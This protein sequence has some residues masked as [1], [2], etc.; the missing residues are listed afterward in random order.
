MPTG[1]QLAAGSRIEPLSIDGVIN[2][3]T[4]LHAAISIGARG[5]QEV[6][7]AI[8]LNSAVCHIVVFGIEVVPIPADKLPVRHRGPVSAKIV[9][10][11]FVIVIPLVRDHDASLGI[12]IAKVAVLA[13]NESGLH[14]AIVVEIIRSSRTRNRESCQIARLAMINIL[15][16]NERI[17]ISK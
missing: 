2:P 11:G 4:M 1:Q 6:V 16:T 17:N 14:R 13:S 9:P 3:A 7:F 15:K 12:E 5:V 8:N 10:N